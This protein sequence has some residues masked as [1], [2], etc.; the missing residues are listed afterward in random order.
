MTPEPLELDR[1]FDGLPKH[2]QDDLV[3][4]E[5]MDGEGPGNRYTMDWQAVRLLRAM[6]DEVLNVRLNALR[7]DGR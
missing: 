3:W 7:Y 1:P 6:T 2:V 5:I 4:R